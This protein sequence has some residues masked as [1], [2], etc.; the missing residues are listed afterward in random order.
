MDNYIEVS[1]NPAALVMSMRSLGYD[2]NMAIADIIDNSITAKA[3][4]IKIGFIWNGKESIIYIKNDGFGMDDDELI[5]A[6]RLGT[7]GPEISRHSDDLGRFGMG[8][9]T[10]SFS[11]CM[12][13]TVI[14]KKQGLGESIKGWDLNIVKKTNK[15][16]VWSR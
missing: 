3:K 16:L 1:P 12:K 10:A 5:E 15:W 4:T 14:T 8:L 7:N 13:L 9:K 2:L 6:M 11:Q